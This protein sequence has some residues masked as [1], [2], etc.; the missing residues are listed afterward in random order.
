MKKWVTGLA[1]ILM[2][3]SL[4]ACSKTV[5]TTSGGKITESEYYDSMKKTSSG[6][7]VLQQMI[8]DKVLEGNYGKKVSDKKVTAQYNTAKKQY[9]SSFNSI[10]QQNG[11]TKSS[12]KKQLRSSLL[13]QEAVKANTKVTNK[14]LQKQ[15]KSY[16][17]KVTVGHILL[18][19]NDAG[20][21]QAETIIA[22]LKKDGSYKNFKALAKKYSTDTQTKNSG[23]KLPAFDNT[24]TS[25]VSAFKN[26]AFKLKQGEFTAQPVK[27][28]YGYH[29]IY[30]IKN[31]GKGKLSD[32]KAE[33]KKQILDDKMQDSTYMQKVI[34]K[35]LKKGKVNI[36]DSDLKD[37]LSDYIG[38]SSSSK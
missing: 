31:P 29:V 24:D 25:L 5:A 14:Q 26:A 18:K 23:G 15:W 11:M 4:A 6:K 33:L 21:K 9:G 36:K 38:T 19:G 32:H 10:L 1:A 13:L 12:Y 7:Q 37:I 34:S 22:S 30:S 35:E 27:T 20:K 2:A 28:S 17:P 16:Q 8:L 3:F